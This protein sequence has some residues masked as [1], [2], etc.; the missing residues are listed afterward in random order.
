MAT[1]AD[2]I[3]LWNALLPLRSLSYGTIVVCAALGYAS[4]IGLIVLRWRPNSGFR[5]GLLVGSAV[6]L[7]LN[8]QCYD[9]FSA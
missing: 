7:L 8:T 9:T 5:N 1:P 3:E 6:M 2:R 4:T